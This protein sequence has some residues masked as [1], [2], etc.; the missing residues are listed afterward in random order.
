MDSTD[1]PRFAQLLAGIAEVYGKTLTAP[2]ISVYWHALKDW[3]LPEIVAAADRHV[4]NPDTGQFMPKPADLIHHL[5]GN[6]DGQALAAWSAVEAAIRHVGSWRS[7]EFPDP[8]TSHIVGEMGGWL[9][10]CET[11]EAEIPFTRQEFTRRY[12]AALLAPP[13]TETRTLPG[14]IEMANAAQGYPPPP[15]VAIGGPNQPRLPTP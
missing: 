12:R 15:P 10:L 3:P 13:P 5:E 14:R 9:R 7:V 6:G 11:S 1:K 4:R 8:R 2:A